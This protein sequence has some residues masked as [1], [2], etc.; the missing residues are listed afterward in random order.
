[1]KLR[2][3]FISYAL[4][5][6]ILLGA[7]ITTSIFLTNHQTQLLRD[8]SQVEYKRIVEI[9]EREINT[10]YARGVEEMVIDARLNSHI[11]FHQSRNIIL[12][13][14]PFSGQF[15]PRTLFFESYTGDYLIKI[16]GS[17]ATGPRSFDLHVIFDVT[18]NIDELRGIQQILLYFFIIFSLIAAIILYVVFDR[19]FKPL[20]M[21]TES[22]QKIAEGEYSERIHIKGKGELATMAAQ[23]NQMASEIES[24][25]ELLRE[26]A[27]RKQQFMDNLAH[28]IRTPLTSIYGYLEYM[29][30]AILSEEDKL[31]A[32]AYLMEEAKHMKS[33][34]SSILELASLRNT[35]LHKDR[36]SIEELLNQVT[37][38]LEIPFREHQVQ[39]EVQSIDATVMGA[40]ELLK[41][42]LLNLCINGAKA[43]DADIG[44]VTLRATKEGETLV[45]AV[46]DNGCGIPPDEIEKITEPFYQV[47]K[48]RGRSNEGIGLGLTFCKEIV[49]L[50]DGKL[51]IESTLG[52]GTTVRIL[53]TT[54]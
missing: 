32:T 6:S 48:V 40:E 42:L 36:I 21:V 12:S 31:E 15:E 7:F 2:T 47:D 39:L 54:R 50:H 43:C 27:W 19:I 49:R 37:T 5:L 25:V 29:Q 17:V 18:E 4:F 13:I 1:M 11:N 44:K 14:E 51:V 8:Q 28:E 10:V 33:L 23:F 16:E 46:V 41:S 53:F 24:H 34:A 9:I 38:T 30:K 20:E 22:A 3:F 26:E 52:I 35:T 45:L